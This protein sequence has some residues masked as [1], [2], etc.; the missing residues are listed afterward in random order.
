MNPLTSPHLSQKLIAIA[1]LWVG[2]AALVY[3]PSA[4]PGFESSMIAAGGFLAFTAGVLRFSNAHK[5]ELLE[6]L[7]LQARAQADEDEDVRR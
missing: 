7:R 6:E 4:A 2:L 3:V 5:A 1:L